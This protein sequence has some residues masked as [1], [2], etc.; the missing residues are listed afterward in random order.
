[1][2]F[3]RNILFFHVVVI[4]ILHTLI[5]HKHH[6][7]MTYQEH[8]SSHTNAKGIFG[9][10]SLVFQNGSTDTLPYFIFSEQNYLN[11]FEFENLDLL[12]NSDF[13][14]DKLSINLFLIFQPQILYKSLNILICR[15]RG[16]PNYIYFT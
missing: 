10:I 6:S 16:P 4:L 13:I 3:I 5:P 2:N 15:L 1:M 8:Y 9:F 14:Q 12:K 11:K 7:E